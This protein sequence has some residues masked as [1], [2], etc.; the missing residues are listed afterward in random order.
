MDAGGELNGVVLPTHAS[1]ASGRDMVDDRA[2]PASVVLDAGL[3][4]LA[5]ARLEAHMGAALERNP[6]GGG[7]GWGA[8]ARGGARADEWGWTRM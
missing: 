3:L 5:A 1:K 6:V 8:P 2:R 4:G 7:G